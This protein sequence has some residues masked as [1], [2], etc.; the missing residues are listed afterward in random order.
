MASP[1]QRLIDLAVQGDAQAGTALEREAARRNDP[2]GHA[3][4]ALAGPPHPARVWNF[5]ARV[6][7]AQLALHPTLVPLLEAHP[8]RPDA[9][10]EPWALLDRLP[11]NAARLELAPP[12]PTTTRRGRLLAHTGLFDVHEA[13]SDVPS[14][15]GDVLKISHRELEPQHLETLRSTSERLRHRV[16]PHLPTHRG[17]MTDATGTVVLIESRIKGLFL[18]RRHLRKAGPTAAAVAFALHAARALYA[19][20]EAT[21]TPY[22]LVPHDF[23]IT[24]E[25]RVVFL[26]PSL[27]PLYGQMQQE[28]GLLGRVYG[29]APE[30]LRQPSAPATPQASQFALGVLTFELLT[31]K[32]PHEGSSTVQTLSQLFHR[33]PVPPSSI[34]P[35]VPQTLDR[36]LTR[37]LARDPAKRFEDFSILADTLERCFYT[38]CPNAQSSPEAQLR[39]F[40]LDS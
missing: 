18:D 15:Q 32:H 27:Q 29:H 23:V 2:V 39:A 31:G 1:Y 36:I 25:G 10:L 34:V 3:I 19:L 28:D 26:S 35:D 24:R 13:L 37:M 17:L 11:H 21:C 4:A 14:P 22:T 20:V 40:A 9:T 38:R 5:H 12:Q 30:V 8:N 33:A 7:R 16:H 6:A